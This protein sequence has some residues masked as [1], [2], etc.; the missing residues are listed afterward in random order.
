MKLSRKIKRLFVLTLL[1][2]T[3][4]FIFSFLAFTYF[5]ITAGSIRI[6]VSNLKEAIS[7]QNKS[8]VEVQESHSDLRN[9]SIAEELDLHDASPTKATDPSEDMELYLRMSTVN[10]AL[11]KFYESVLVQSMKYFWPTN[12]SMVM[13]LDKERPA[14]H[15]FGNT[16]Q[17][18]F[19]F[20]RVCYMDPVTEVRFSGMHRM[21]RDMFYPELCTNKTFVAFI[22]TDTMF[23]TRVIPKML[24][25]EGKPIVVGIYGNIWDHHYVLNSQ[26]TANIFQTKEVMRCM[27]NFPI[28]FKAEHLVGLR[29]HVEKLHNMTFEAVL[30]TKKATTFSQFN[31][32]CQYVWMFHRDEYKF[33]LSYQTKKRT[34][35]KPVREGQD[36]YDK[37][38]TEEQ[39]TPVVRVALHYKYIVFVNWRFEK[40][41]R[42][43]FQIS[44]CYMGGFDL[45]PDKCVGVKK[46]TLRPEMFIFEYVDWTWDKRCL[47]LQ[48]EHYQRLAA[49]ASPW[50]TNIIKNA[51]IDL[52]TM[53]WKL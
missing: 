48:R 6:Y 7:L 17:K 42:F 35:L 24:F 50:Y 26:S 53:K 21:Q 32:M 49:Y 33:H 19:P 20:P 41:W 37:H 8:N 12:F 36:Y 44:I 23:I 38:L 30:F 5:N 4:I 45:C 15:T 52:N 2:C 14:D 39:K 9:K 18:S 25:S 31:L 43:L 29:K 27:S 11:P 13:V 51:C 3:G 34:S 10:Q 22:D 28:I 40:T 46:D 16:T 47:A 1:V